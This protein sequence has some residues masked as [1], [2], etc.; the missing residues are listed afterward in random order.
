MRINWRWSLRRLMMLLVAGLMKKVGLG[1]LCEEELVVDREELRV[2][3]H[4]EGRRRKEGG[5]LIRRL[6]CGEWRWRRREGSGKGY[7]RRNNRAGGRGRGS[8]VRPVALWS[9]SCSLDRRLLWALDLR[10][11]LD[12]GFAEGGVALPLGA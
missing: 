8:C 1:G 11:E 2:G 6:G 7:G 12:A 10:L 5:G 9:G 4:K 3:H